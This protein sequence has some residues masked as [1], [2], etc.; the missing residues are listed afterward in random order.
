[1]SLL[2]LYKKE[3]F[4]TARSIHIRQLTFTKEKITRQINERALQIISDYD[5]IFLQGKRNFPRSFFFSNLYLMRG[6]EKEE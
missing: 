3:S 1:M 6:Q 2:S 4:P 5:S